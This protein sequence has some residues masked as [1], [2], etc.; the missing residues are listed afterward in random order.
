[1]DN[2]VTENR[3]RALEGSPEELRRETLQSQIGVCIQA[4][5]ASSLLTPGFPWETAPAS[6][7]GLLLFPRALRC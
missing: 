5:S 7:S 3:F 6:A 1:M 4:S 2:L